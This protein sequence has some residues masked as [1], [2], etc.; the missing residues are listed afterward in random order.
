MPSGKYNENAFENAVIEVLKNT[1]WEY[2]YGPD[3]EERD[4]HDPV[5]NDVFKYQL[6]KLNRDVPDDAITAA[7]HRVKEIVSGSLIERIKRLVLE[8]GP[9]KDAFHCYPIAEMV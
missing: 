9:H 1:K 6:R 4:Y 2:T 3:I 7:F 8:D 5:L